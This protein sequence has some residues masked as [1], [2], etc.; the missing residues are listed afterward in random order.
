[1]RVSCRVIRDGRPCG[2]AP[3]KLYMPCNPPLIDHLTAVQP[4]DGCERSIFLPLTD[5]ILGMTAWLS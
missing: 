2:D 1:M 3:K 4:S 5:E